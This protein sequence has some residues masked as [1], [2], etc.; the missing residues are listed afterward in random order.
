MSVGD[1]SP[2][3]LS[4]CADFWHDHLRFSRAQLKVPSLVT[5]M[6]RVTGGVTRSTRR[7]GG[8]WTSTTVV[9]DADAAYV[10]SKWL[11]DAA[12]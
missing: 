5:K 10:T 2:G 12:A 3:V 7:R 1:S 6:L 8:S 4:C 11:A 9:P